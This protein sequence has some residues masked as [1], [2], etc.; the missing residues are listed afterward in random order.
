MIIIF[1]IIILL[2]LFYYY[3]LLPI[4][5]ADT[6]PDHIR[7]GEYFMNASFQNRY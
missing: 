4:A 3:F 2:L 6:S 7:F 1:F 5:G